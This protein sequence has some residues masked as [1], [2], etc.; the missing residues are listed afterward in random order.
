MNRSRSL[1]APCC[2]HP[3]P[4]VQM[5]SVYGKLVYIIQDSVNPAIS[6]L[7]GFHL[8]RSERKAALDSRDFILSVERWAWDPHADSAPILFVSLCLAVSVP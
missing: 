7:M 6:E 5:R 4:L 8:Y 1:S 2:P 3:T